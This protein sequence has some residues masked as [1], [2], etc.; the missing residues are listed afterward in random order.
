MNQT[1][2]TFFLGN[3]NEYSI[4]ST[5]KLKQHSTIYLALCI[6]LT[7][8]IGEEPDSDPTPCRH[9]DGVPLHR[10]DEVEAGRGA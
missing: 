9:S 3:K 7:R 1:P 4:H 2:S 5:R 8:I 6:E 10:V